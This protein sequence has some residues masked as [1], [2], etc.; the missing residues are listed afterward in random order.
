MVAWWMVGGGPFD[1]PVRGDEGFPGNRHLNVLLGRHLTAPS[2]F[3]LVRGT[4]RLGCDPT[5][6]VFWHRVLA[7]WCSGTVVCTVVLWHRVMHRGVAP[8]SG[9]VAKSNSR[10]CNKISIG[11]AQHVAS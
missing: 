7:P 1:C 6:T 11:E 9:L 3:R 10:H 5:C 8:C 2:Q 4:G